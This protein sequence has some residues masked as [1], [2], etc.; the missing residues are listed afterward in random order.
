[1][2]I[3]GLVKS[4]LIDYPGMIAAVVFTPGCNLRCS[5]CHNP[6]LLDADSAASSSTQEEILAWLRTRR[7][8]LDAVVVSGGEPTL[9]PGLAEFMAKIRALGYLVKLDTNGTQPDVL[10]SLI[11]NG[12]LDYVAMDIKAPPEKYQLICGVRVEPDGL[13]ASINFL[14]SGRVDYE[15]R[16]TVVPQ[17][18]RADIFSIGRRIKGARLYVLQQYR[19]PRQVARLRGM[20]L[21]KSLAHSSAWVLEVMEDLKSVVRDCG[22]RGFE[23]NRF[24]AASRTEMGACLL[25]H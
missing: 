11:G 21:E 18:T 17:L 20:R 14:L 3:A 7:G 5:Y 1:M 2:R 25:P 23:I 6:E 12:V 19:L 16:T 22:A 24:P 13:D 15:F 8:L 10:A 9:Q 4:S